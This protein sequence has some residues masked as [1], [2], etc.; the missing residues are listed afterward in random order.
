MAIISSHLQWNQP[1]VNALG[2]AGDPSKQ[3]GMEKYMRFQFPFYGVQAPLRKE[4]VKGHL[5][6]QEPISS[7]EMLIEIC[8]DLWLG[9]QSKRE[10]TYAAMDILGKSKKCWNT[11]TIDTIEQLGVLQSWWDTVD[12]LVIAGVGPYFQLFPSGMESKTNAWNS[13]K[14]IWLK[15]WSVIFQLGYKEKTNEALLFHYI[16]NLKD[17]KEF[18][19]AKGIGWALRQYARTNP[20]AVQKFVKGTQ[21]QPL[22]KRE[23]LKHLI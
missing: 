18:F 21:L 13:S 2:K 1:L 20:K 9:P 6:T 17:E 7:N 22:S 14:N 10:A 4:I 8:K 12:G 16:T 5:A 3:L 15:R 23:A 11:S 19:V